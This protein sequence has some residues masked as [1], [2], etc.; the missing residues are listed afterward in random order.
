MKCSQGTKFNEQW[1]S[2]LD[3]NVMKLKGCTQYT[4]GSVQ[5]VGWNRE[6][7]Q[8]S[9]LETRRQFLYLNQYLLHLLIQ[10]HPRNCYLKSKFFFLVYPMKILKILLTYLSSWHQNYFFYSLGIF[11]SISKTKHN[12]SND[13]K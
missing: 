12:M 4:I 13:G 9:V 8:N 3:T 5:T 1:L 10:V 6:R 7:I 11:Y 2:D